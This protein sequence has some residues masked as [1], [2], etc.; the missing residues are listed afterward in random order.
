MKICKKCNIEKDITEYP[1]MGGRLCKICFNEYMK[2]RR[3]K[4]EKVKINITH[5]V[6]KK[7]NIEKD[8]NNF[9]IGKAYKDGYRNVC[10][11]C[12]NN[13][14]KGNINVKIYYNN[15]RE[16]IL[17]YQKEYFV[18]NEFVRKEYNKNNWYKWFKN[19]I[20]TDL[21]FRLKNDIKR[22]LYK[23]F[24]RAGFTKSSKTFDILG[25]S[26]EDFKLHIEKQFEPWMNWDNRGTCSKNYN[27]TWQLDHIIPISSANNEEEIIKLNHY[28]NLRPLCSRKN[29]EKGN[30]IID[31]TDLCNLNTLPN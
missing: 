16:K 22:T 11:D 7:C 13:L 21:N 8:I 27:E 18:K 5:K 19:K 1:K 6:C 20:E 25:C 15:N 30:K 10:K 2:E 26:Y 3:P 14:Q 31:V 29:L 12:Y 24:K 28:T 17:Q 9:P 4:K 23:A